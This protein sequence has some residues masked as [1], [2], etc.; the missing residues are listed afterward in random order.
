MVPGT[1]NEQRFYGAH[2]LCGIGGRSVS[3]CEMALQQLQWCLPPL[4]GMCLERMNRV[5]QLRPEIG[6]CSQR[7][8]PI[9]EAGEELLKGG[10]AEPKAT[11]QTRPERAFLNCSRQGVGAIGL[12]WSPGRKN[13]ADMRPCWPDSQD[14]IT[15]GPPRNAGLGSGNRRRGRRGKN[16]MIIFLQM[17]TCPV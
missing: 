11:I 15:A 7:L 2:F 10:L 13:Q 5:P 9:S 16:V 3:I 12:I 6:D 4:E 1:F 14:R 17:I 8:V